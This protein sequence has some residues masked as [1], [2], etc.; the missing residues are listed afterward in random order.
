MQLSGHLTA[1]VFDRYDIHD[2]EDLKAATAKLNRR[3]HA[4]GTL[5]EKTA[6]EITGAGT[7]VTHS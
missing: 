5:D 1:S 4:M 7:C 3:G 2:L 6:P